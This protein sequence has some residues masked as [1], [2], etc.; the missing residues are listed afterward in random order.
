[1]GEMA[2][3]TKHSVGFYGSLYPRSVQTDFLR[4]EHSSERQLCLA[5]CR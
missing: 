3:Q 4:A 2:K 1:M 5:L